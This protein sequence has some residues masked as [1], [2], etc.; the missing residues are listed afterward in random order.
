MDEASFTPR[1]FQSCKKLDGGVDTHTGWTMRHATRIIDFYAQSDIFFF[2]WVYLKDAGTWSIKVYLHVC[3]LDFSCLRW[4][5]LL[6]IGCIIICVSRNRFPYHI[7]PFASLWKGQRMLMVRLLNE[8]TKSLIYLSCSL[9][10]NS[11][12]N[13]VYFSNSANNSF[14]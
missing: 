12:N 5:S 6:Y 9:L 3:K 11:A 10:M 8:S 14:R 1:D 13:L 4:I 2:V 7:V